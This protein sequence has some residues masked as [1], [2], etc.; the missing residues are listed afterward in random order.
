MRYALST[1]LLLLAVGCGDG[2]GD[3]GSMM[4]GSR[5]MMGSG[6]YGNGS[7]YGAALVSVTPAGGAVGVPTSLSIVLRFGAPMAAGTEQYV[8]LHVAGI[9][10]PIVPV[11]CAFSSDRT[12]LTCVP[13]PPLAS[14]TTYLI[15]VGGGMM[16]Q[17]GHAIDYDYYAPGMGGRWIMGGMMGRNHAGQAWGMMGPGWRGPNGSYGMEFPFTT[18]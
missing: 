14:R 4:T 5:G 11:G 8:D 13:N 7:A 2:G 15:H 17:D 16:T 10:G 6:G 9:D 3:H 12:T 18:A 1:L